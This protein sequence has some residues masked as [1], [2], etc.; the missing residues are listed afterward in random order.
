M[1]FAY[2]F[3]RGGNNMTPEEDVEA[4]VELH[5]SA[6][7]LTAQQRLVTA[8]LGGMAEAALPKRSGS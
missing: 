2:V 4:R 6:R 8:R 3:A 5:I 7:A 1:T